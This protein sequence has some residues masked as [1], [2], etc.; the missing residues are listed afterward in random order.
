MQHVTIPQTAGLRT[1]KDGLIKH[2]FSKAGGCYSVG[3]DTPGGHDS[4]S[5]SLPLKCLS[6]PVYATILS[7]QDCNLQSF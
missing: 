2:D 6:A 5:S 3:D 4:R 7:L 1:N